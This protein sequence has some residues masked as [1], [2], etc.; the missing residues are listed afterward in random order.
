MDVATGSYFRFPDPRSVA[1]FRARGH[2]M[3]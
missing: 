3:L 1:E 2:R